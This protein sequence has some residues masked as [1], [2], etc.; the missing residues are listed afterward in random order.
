MAK[1]YNKIP[2]RK[3]IGY[4][5]TLGYL[6]VTLLVL[7]VFW[8]F[9]LKLI[10]NNFSLLVQSQFASVLDAHEKTIEQYFSGPETWARHLASESGIQAILTMD[11][12]NN[13]KTFF[14]E[15]KMV[16]FEKTFVI[17]LNK[18]GNVLY[19]SRK[20][21]QTGDSLMGVELVR[22]VAKS[23]ST[24][25]AIVSEANNFAF[26]SAS[27][28]FQQNSDN[29][30]LGFVI[31]GKSIDNQYVS[32]LQI[33]GDVE[34]AIVRDRAVMASTMSIDGMPLVDIPMSYVEYLSLLKKSRSIFEIEFL[35]QKYFVSA[36]KIQRMSGNMAGS[37]MLLKPRAELER[38]EA[39]LFTKFAYVAVL[40]LMI[41]WLSSRIISRKLLTPVTQLT[42]TSIEIAHGKRGAKA[43]VTS[44]DELGVLASS[45][46]S[47]LD[48]IERQHD[49]I[50]RQKDTLEEKVEL[51]TSELKMAMKD[52]M[53]LTV[54]VEQSPVGMII[55]DSNGVIEY[56]NPKFTELSG[57]S[58][59][60][61]VGK[62]WR[63]LKYD[64][65]SDEEY[66]QLWQQLNSGRS[67]QGELLSKTKSGA[68]YWEQLKITPIKDDNDTISHYLISMEDI[69]NIK[70]YEQKLIEQASYDVL[71]QLPNRFLAEDRLK[72]ALHSSDRNGTKGALLFVDLD[73]F[74]PVNDTYGHHTGDELLKT[75]SLLM[76]QE[77]RKEDTVAR[78]GG[79]EFLIILNNIKNIHEIEKIAEKII[80]SVSQ[81]IIIA[82]H[83]IAVSASIGITVFP[84][85]ADDEESLLQNADSA[86]YRAKE[87]GKN[88]F[89]FFAN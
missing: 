22:Q 49:V 56:I 54:A 29:E 11:D 79:D 3:S 13:I 68:L 65:I 87:Q 71:T 15:H 1:E 63:I 39:E 51:R 44:E 19:C 77:L 28:V 88:C 43:N 75:V 50:K 38:I 14:D 40:S 67:W 84:D 23:L 16:L 58:K 5:I 25:S 78:L 30:L 61:S 81:D 62:T 89:Y 4:K 64:K 24:H 83:S 80:S 10:Q 21:H 9:S 85:D 42:M 52:L 34:V 82:Q 20:C 18:E 31:V 69:S 53:K 27:P 32:G 57:Y 76:S 37:I 2:Y 47:M 70:E 35:K 8:L 72:Q 74:K 86:M 36:Q 17:I 73:D 12:Q 26:Y 59:I 46:N 60:D 45:F 7:G 6:S 41:I 66:Q 48:K 55:T 33:G